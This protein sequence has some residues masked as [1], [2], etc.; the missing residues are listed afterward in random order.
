MLFLVFQPWGCFDLLWRFGLDLFKLWC[1]SFVRRCVRNHHFYADFGFAWFFALFCCSVPSCVW[2]F[3]RYRP[4]V[5]MMFG[6][7]CLWLN[8][9]ILTWRRQDWGGWGAAVSWVIE[10]KA[11]A[12]FSGFVCIGHGWDF[13]VVH[14]LALA[15]WNH[16]PISN[17]DLDNFRPQR[18]G[19][20][21][22]QNQGTYTFISP[23]QALLP[24][25]IK[26]L[27]SNFSRRHLGEVFSDDS[28]WVSTL[29]IKNNL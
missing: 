16:R 22:S 19:H 2:L 17:F 28:R 20:L 18:A 13:S 26:L 21:E 24:S 12:W 5:L 27:I 23:G 8:W 29:L 15:I 6:L 3:S 10:K 14:T 7:G 4:F 9:N 1:G 25:S 11:A